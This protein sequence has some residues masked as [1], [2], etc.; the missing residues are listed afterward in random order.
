MK[1][2]IVLLCLGLI[3]CATVPG[4]N[5]VLRSTTKKTESNIKIVPAAKTG[6]A[7]KIETIVKTEPPVDLVEMDNIIE[8]F[9]DAIKNNPNDA[10]AY[11][12][13]AVAYFHKKDYENSWQD[14]HKAE[15]LGI[16]ID[17]TFTGLVDKLK[18]ASGREK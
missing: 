10:G 17:S 9:S 1:K 3:G 8:I 16:K 14:V 13:R 12:N 4:N 11:Y 5:K 15:T 18:K 7:V 6:T 2:I